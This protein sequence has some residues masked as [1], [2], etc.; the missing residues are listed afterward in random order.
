[1]L[2]SDRPYS[3]QARAQSG[4]IKYITMTPSGGMGSAFE[5]YDDDDAIR[6]ASKAGYTVLDIQAMMDG[7]P[8]LVIP[9]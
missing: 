5:A 8:I 6:Q 2:D 3:A 4:K 9:E 1:M 7:T